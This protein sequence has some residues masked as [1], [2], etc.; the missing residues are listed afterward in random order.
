M[1]IERPPSNDPFVD[2]LLGFVWAIGV[3]S[4]FVA[5]V[6]ISRCDKLDDITSDCDDFGKFESN[7]FDESGKKWQWYECKKLGET[8]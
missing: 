6:S 7:V 1:A 2:R 4:V 8:K 5:A 3:V